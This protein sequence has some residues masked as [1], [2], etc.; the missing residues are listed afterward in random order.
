[1]APLAKGAAVT[2][3][4]VLIADDVDQVRTDLRMALELAG[5]LE[6]V[7]EAADGHQALDLAARL[8]PQVVLMDLE[9]PGLD[10][11][12]AARRLR[13]DHPACRVIALTVHGDEASRRRAREAGIEAFVVKGAGLGALLRVIT[14]SEA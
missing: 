13:A 14:G 8:N 4:R 9:M 2:P 3:L 5:G 1:V 11:C 7:G 6:V 12:A 10:G